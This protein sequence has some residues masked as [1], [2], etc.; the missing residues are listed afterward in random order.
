MIVSLAA[1]QYGTFV[2]RVDQCI[3]RITCAS[4]DV[5][6]TILG[7]NHLYINKRVVA[8]DFRLHD[9]LAASEFKSKVGCRGSVDGHVHAIPTF[10]SV[11]AAAANKN[12]IP[13]VTQ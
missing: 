7:H 10:D 1:Q 6:H 4:D 3:I 5:K 13:V 11:V 2:S 8:V 9:Q 12:I